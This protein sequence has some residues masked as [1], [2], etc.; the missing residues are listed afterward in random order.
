MVNGQDYSDL[1]LLD[2]EMSGISNPAIDLSVW[3]SFYPPEVLRNSELD[4]LVVYYKALLSENPSLLSTYSFER[5]NEDYLSIGTSHTL[6][7]NV[8]LAG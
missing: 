3:F 8:G 5:L 7:R 6:V 4:W 1:V 2:W